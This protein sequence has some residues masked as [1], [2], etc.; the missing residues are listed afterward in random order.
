MT[1]NVGQNYP[2]TSESE[3]D[4]AAAVQRVSGVTVQEGRYVFVRGLGERYTTTS[5]NGARILGL[6]FKSDPLCRAERFERLRDTFGDAF[7][8]IEID[9]RHAK[10]GTPLPPHSVLT[11]HLIDRAGEPTRAALDRTLAFL[12]EQLRQ[13]D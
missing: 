13:S 9:D 4:R 6:R 3:A 12:A 8:G 5:L 7:E 1:S 11:T 10:K 2:Y